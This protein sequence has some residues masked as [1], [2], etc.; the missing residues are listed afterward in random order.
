MTATNRSV[1]TNTILPHL[2]YTDVSAAI[3]YLSAAFGF[4]EHYRYGN[5]SN[6]QG[7]QIRLGNAYIQLEKL[8]SP[9]PSDVA[10]RLQYLTVM[11][12]DV[13]AHYHNAIASGCPIIEPLNDTVYGERQYVAQDHEGHNWL[14]SQHM[15]DLDPSTWG[16][17][18]SEA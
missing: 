16:A 15:H 14:F 18:V 8:R 9:L 17:T 3:T 2:L 10:P 6:P 11:L 1:P 4:T 12:E 5:P 13:T 7:A